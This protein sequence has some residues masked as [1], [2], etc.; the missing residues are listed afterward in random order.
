MTKKWTAETQQNVTD[1]FSFQQRQLKTIQD[2]DTPAA[3]SLLQMG[4]NRLTHK[5]DALY[6]KICA[7]L[8]LQPSGSLRDI[9]ASGAAV[10]PNW[11]K[12]AGSA[13]ENGFA[14][15]AALIEDCI[16]RAAEVMP[17]LYRNGTVATMG[18][19]RQARTL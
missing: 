11:H 5:P 15:T 10:D 13:K 18:K 17:A 16:T 4:F 9:M 1:Y 2:T 7:D 3:L 12:I 19:Y 6:K 8:D 14:D